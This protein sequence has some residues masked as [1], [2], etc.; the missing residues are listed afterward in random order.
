MI[1]AQCFLESVEYDSFLKDTQLKY[2]IE[3]AL[4]IIGEASKRVP[5][6]IRE[7]YPEIPWKIMGRMRDRVIHGYDSVNLKIIWDTVKNDIP[8]VKPLIQKMLDDHQEITENNI[9][10]LDKSID[11][12]P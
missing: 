11:K 3:R 6:E 10:D 8:E 5:A 4:E 2:A 9:E 7:Q 12:R 1:L